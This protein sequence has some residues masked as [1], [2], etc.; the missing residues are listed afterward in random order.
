MPTWIFSLSLAEYESEMW[1]RW[2]CGKL[3]LFTCGMAHAKV[4]EGIKAEQI[5]IKCDLLKYSWFILTMLKLSFY[6]LMLLSKLNLS[7]IYL[8]QFTRWLTFI[9]LTFPNAKRRARSGTESHLPRQLH[10]SSATLTFSKKQSDISLMHN[11]PFQKQIRHNKPLNG[12]EGSMLFFRWKS[13]AAENVIRNLKM[14]LRKE[15]Q[16]W[17][18]LRS[19]EGT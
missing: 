17:A 5:V 9:A 7:S 12:F 18:M 1:H 19:V 15:K 2:F 6:R 10:L 4:T 16:I 8:P 11:E 13:E 14:M 3:R